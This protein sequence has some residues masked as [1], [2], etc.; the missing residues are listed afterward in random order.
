[1]PE[2]AGL[3]PRSS[4]F[5]V[6]AGWVDDLREQFLADPASVSAGWREFF[7]TDVHDPSALPRSTA[8]PGQA[9]PASVQAPP[10]AAALDGRSAPPPDRPLVGS[11]ARVAEA[12]A[13]SLAVPTATTVRVIPARL[14]EV[15]RT[16]ANRHLV[17]SG[18]MRVTLTHFIAYAVLK[19]LAESPVLRTTHVE[20]PSGPAARAH[21][22]VDLG[23]A[24]DVE[25]RDG[26]RRLM[27]PV[28]RQADTFDFSQFRA[29]YEDAV[30]RVR[31][32][33]ATPEELA[34]P[35]VTLTNPGM[36]G[37]SASV[38]RLP[39]GQSAIVAVGAVTFP[40]E[41]A[42]A[43]PRAVAELG[44]S[45]TV[46]LTNTYDHRVIGGADSGRFLTRV[47]DLLLGGALAGGEGFYD[48]IFG[49]LR[50]PYRAVAW[51]ADS[52]PPDHRE[53]RL[54]KQVKVQRLINLYRVRGHLIADLDPLGLAAPVTH[55]ELDPANLGLSIWDL[56]REFFVDGV[57]GREQM[58]LGD[59][60][61]L[62]R[63]A[64]CRH[65]GVEYMHMSD[66]EPKRW[67]QDRVERPQHAI[68]GGD[69]QRILG[70]LN[71]AEAFERFL[72]TKYVGHKRFG[73]E[74][75]ESLIPILD[76]LLGEAAGAGVG[77]VV[78]GMAHRGRLN[79][80]ANIVGKP[81]AQMFRAFDGDLDPATTQGSGDVQYHLGAAGIFTAACGGRVA[82]TLASNPSHLEA[83]G[84]VVVGMVRALR[85][86]ED[87]RDTGNECPEGAGAVPILIHGDAAFA[88]QGVVAETLNLSGLSGYR[89]GGT[90]HV[91]INNQLGFTTSITEARSSTYPTDV[92]KAVQAPIFHVNGDDPEACVRVARVAFDFR[93]TFGRDVVIDLVCYRRNGHN[94]GDDPSYTQPVMYRRIAR[95]RS[96]R[97]LYTEALIRRGDISEAETEGALADFS[98]R[99]QAAFAA[100]RSSLDRPVVESNPA[101]APAV[102]GPEA[103]EDEKRSTDHGPDT[104][105]DLDRLSSLVEGL[106][107]LPPGFT[108]HPKLEPQWADRQRMFGAG[109][110]DWALAEALALGSL[111]GDGHDVRLSGQDSQR[112]TFA[113]RHAVLVDYLTGGEYT[114]LANLDMPG[115][116]WVVDSSL[117]EYAALG[118]EYGYS[119]IAANS[120]VIWEAQFGDFVNGAQ[121][122]V[123]Q[124][125][126]SAQDKWGQNSRLVLLLPHGYEGQGPEHSSA[127]LERFLTL[128]AGENLT[129]VSP[130]TAAQ[131]FHLLRRQ[132]RAQASV[133]MVVMAPKS[134]LRSRAWRSAVGELTGGRFRP[135]LA[136]PNPPSTARRVLLAS[137]KV[138]TEAIAAR[139]ANSY[140]VAVLRVESLHP[141]PGQELA[142][143]LER[144]PGSEVVWLQEE[145]KNM[146]AGRWALDRLAEGGI[147]VVDRVCRPVSP[148]PATGSRVTHERE[149]AAL[150]T[151][152]FSGVR[153]TDRVPSPRGHP[154]NA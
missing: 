105:V 82:V 67:I 143:L 125:I 103:D 123:D 5:G 87:G 28:I 79:V 151:A 142:R 53:G 108:V 102:A 74:G 139:D 66:P 116:A 150:M 11:A 99:M 1:M 140:P 137:G 127:R 132:A 109:T 83:V 91:V 22:H 148:S 112:G 7:H 101:S 47:H 122:V 84:P 144:Y 121:I 43:D 15:N 4:S 152:A 59:L 12:M 48:D 46:T 30:A 120:L 52:N 49:S 31:T 63:D 136:D 33:R 145:P 119:T 62:L 94:E 70:C 38:A 3:A 80:L 41:F 65:V 146:G 29:A 89:V 45:K 135:V 26:T 154:G 54:A 88:G 107:R 77:Q 51:M 85:D 90:I 76:T 106:H 10:S 20:T 149:Q 97:M 110:V 126:A 81:L 50:V 2:P 115:R 128:C 8:G 72:H 39:A 24:V 69:Q 9:Q 21:E 32:G 64:Y 96:V 75:A 100:T 61:G 19:A 111:L 27:V 37:T 117:S 113:H 124:F 86:A 13:A 95:Q 55:P 35:L 134:G 18:G 98:E 34:G 129:V 104:C 56:E 78:M 42:G 44:V 147:D 73:L 14:L 118:F 36:L 17:R 153:G 25:R 141:W 133:P 16:I 68:A 40:A 131:Y 6:N 92:A 58:T 138:A 71:A 60:L 114:P 130:T 57:G 93:R 23:V